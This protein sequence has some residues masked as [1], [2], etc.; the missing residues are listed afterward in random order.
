MFFEANKDIM[1]YK[2][3]VLIELFN[4]DQKEKII[5]CFKLFFNTE[6]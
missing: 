2:M 1:K 4:Q 5:E 3:K 6:E